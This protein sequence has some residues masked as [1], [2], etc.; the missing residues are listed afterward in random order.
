MVEVKNKY[1]CKVFVTNP[2]KIY[3]F[4]KICVNYQLNGAVNSTCYL[5]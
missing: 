2:K 5:L 3:N 1:L 4:I